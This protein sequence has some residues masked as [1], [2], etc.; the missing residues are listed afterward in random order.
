MKKGKRTFS[1]KTLLSALAATLALTGYFYWQNNGLTITQHHHCDPMIPEEFNDFTIL[2]VSDLH[3]KSYGKDQQILLDNLSVLSPDIILITGDLVDRRRF[4]LEKAMTFVE[5]AVA[6]APVYYVSGNHEAWSGRYDE[7]RN[8]LLEAGVVV[9]DNQ[10]AQ[11]E[12][13]GDTLHLLG[14]QDP[15]FQVSSYREQWDASQVSSQLNTW[16]ELEG[17]KILLAHRP[18]LFHLY[19]ESQMN[20][21][22]SG[23]AHGGQ[24]RLP[25][26]G[27]LFAPD[28]GFFP[29]YTDGDYHQESTT[30]Y[31]SRGLGNSIFPL[32]VHNRPELIMVTLRKN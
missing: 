6:L 11:Q 2:Q 18:E 22:F 30:M 24:I 5:G 16:Q 29:A 1:E 20:V 14:L 28:Q 8:A 27:S 13:K 9:L 32:R 10:R 15:A 21:I 31:V 4:D 12:R 17:Y 19:A 25:F 23:H 7:I 3:N 26:L